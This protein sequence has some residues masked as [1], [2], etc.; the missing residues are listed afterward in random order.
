MPPLLAVISSSH[1]S[2]K[3]APVSRS[4]LSE[5]NLVRLISQI[6]LAIS[7]RQLSTKDT[8]T[9]SFADRGTLQASISYHCPIAMA[10]RLSRIIHSPAATTAAGDNE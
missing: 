10:K 4:G 3:A 6:Q 2:T 5:S 1:R 7:I 8:P 9:P